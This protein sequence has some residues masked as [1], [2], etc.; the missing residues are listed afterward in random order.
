[1]QRS[2]EIKNKR[3]YLLIYGQA[4]FWGERHLGENLSSFLCDVSSS[5]PASL[6][7]F[8]IWKTTRFLITA[9]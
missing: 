7:L 5:Q 2:W 6:S 1:M 8:L 4:Y 3:E 9:K